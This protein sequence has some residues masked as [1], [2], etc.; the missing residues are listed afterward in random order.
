MQFHYSITLQTAILITYE[1]QKKNHTVTLDY[2]KEGDSSKV[3]IILGPEKQLN[4]V[5]F[6]VRDNRRTE[7]IA[8]IY[9]TKF[10]VY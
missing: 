1:V 3:N 10:L 6:S 2:R 5:C 8:C 4:Y 9:K 7:H